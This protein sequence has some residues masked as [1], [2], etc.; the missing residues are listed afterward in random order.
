VINLFGKKIKEEREKRGLSISD[1]SKNTGIDTQTLVGIE[2]GVIFPN[3]KH[4]MDIAKSFGNHEGFF[5]Q[6]I[7]FNNK[8]EQ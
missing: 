2:S 4:L 6:S 8:N 1:V 7:L 5:L 3:T